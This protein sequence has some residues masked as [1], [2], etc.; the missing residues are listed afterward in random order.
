MQSGSDSFY[1]TDMIAYLIYKIKKEHDIKITLNLL[2]R[3]FDE[4]RAWKFAGADNYLLKFNTSNKDNFSVFNR[5]NKLEDRINH[6]KYLKRIGYEVCTGSIVGLPNQS[7]EDIAN[8]LLLLKQFIPEM[9]CNTPFVPHYFPRFKNVPQIELSLMMKIISITR[10]LQKKS[11]III[12]DSND[13]FNVNQKK[14]LFEVGANTLLLEYTGND[15]KN[16]DDFY[17]F[18]PRNISAKGKIVN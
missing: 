12:S 5:D 9:I 7:I 11:D 4:Y 14:E 16:K 10:L 1:D 6:I 18:E 15:S 17:K 3:G 13:F 2:Q 8:D